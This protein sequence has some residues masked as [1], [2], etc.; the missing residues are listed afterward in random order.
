MKIE[1]IAALL[2]I[3]SGTGIG[4]EP[5]P[6]AIFG[7]RDPAVCASRKDPAKGA[8]SVSQATAYFSC[9]SELLNGYLYLVSDVKLQVAPSSRRFNI[10]TDTTGIIDPKQPIWDI[11]GT[12]TK[13]QCNNPATGTPGEWP[14]GK[15]C[16]RSDVTNATGM[17]YQDTW[18]F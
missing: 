12:Y 1:T 17:C 5:H 18:L 15:N 6:G 9:D 8:P 10:L 3:L 16:N 14:I 7:A 13:Y 11:R 4:A 2:V